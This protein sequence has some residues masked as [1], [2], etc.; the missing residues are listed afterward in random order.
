MT[1]PIRVIIADDHSIFREGFK[2][3]LKNQQEAILV[4]EA[5]DGHSLI[6]LASETKPDVIVTDIV[7]PGMDGVTATKEIT[8]FLPDV[9][10]IAL[11][12][13]NDDNLIVDMLEAG[14]RG[15]LLK[16]TTKMELLEAI[17]TVYSGNCFYCAATS[18]KLTRLIA[19]SKFNPHK[20]IPRPKFTERELEVIRLVCKEY[21]N[22]EIAVALDLSIR[23]VESYK[24]K[25]IQKLHAK[26]MVG[27]A[28]YA[29]RNGLC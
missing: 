1:E 14:A 18:S 24:E 4:G 17:K 16:N 3:L 25:I 7:M 15:Y 2:L 22:K 21:S 26:N 5:E 27:I 20:H 23:T 11:S 29:V 10:I 19:Q 12:M 6:Q 13:F 9:C 28:V 8:K